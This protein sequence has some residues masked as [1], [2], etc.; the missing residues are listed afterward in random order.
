MFSNI[1]LILFSIN[2]PYGELVRITYISNSKQDSTLWKEENRDE[3]HGKLGLRK[4]LVI[5]RPRTLRSSSSSYMNNTVVSSQQYFS[6]AITLKRKY[7]PNKTSTRPN[8]RSPA[9]NIAVQSLFGVRN[10]FPSP[11]GVELLL[12]FAAQLYD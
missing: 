7:Q 12:L 2:D 5:Y 9:K 1:V 4:L 8:D 11:A 10:V 3:L 6:S